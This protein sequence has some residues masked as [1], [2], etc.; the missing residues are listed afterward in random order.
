MA[1]LQ[2]RNTSSIWHNNQVTNTNDYYRMQHGSQLK[3]F[4]SKDN[5]EIS[6]A[7]CEDGDEEDDMSMLKVECT[8]CH[9]Q[10][11]MAEIDQHEAKCLDAINQ[12]VVEDL[13]Q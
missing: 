2:K 3:P 1:L 11:D 13:I 6:I 8:H 7:K 9:K 12:R 5:N 4:A 10:I